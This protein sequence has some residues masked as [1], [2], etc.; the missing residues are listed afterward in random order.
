[1]IELPTV[2]QSV[3]FYNW[4]KYY[5]GRIYK[6]T[7]VRWTG[8]R[9]PVES[10]FSIS[11]AAKVNRIQGTK[12]NTTRDKNVTQQNWLFH[13]KIFFPLSWQNRS[14]GKR[15]S[16]EE[17]IEFS[18]ILL[19]P[20]V[21]AQNCLEIIK[22]SVKVVLQP[23]WCDASCQQ[24]NVDQ[25][26]KY[27]IYVHYTNFISVSR[28]L[29]FSRQLPALCSNSIFALISVLGLFKKAYSRVFCAWG[30]ATEAHTL[31]RTTQRSAQLQ[32]QVTYW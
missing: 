16:S 28:L 31:L 11:V 15:D 22:M 17:K 13:S 4:L 5:L 32:V 9:S 2:S 27:F 12:Q 6:F 23:I 8:L 14:P 21:N 26:P 20:F 7:R 25:K 24:N 18:K 30:I 3:S 29:L 19:L 10:C 1:M